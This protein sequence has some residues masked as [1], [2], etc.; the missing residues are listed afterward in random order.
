MTRLPVQG[1]IAAAALAAA[2]FSGFLYRNR[3]EASFADLWLYAALYVGVVLVV[4]AAISF[5]FGR[6]LGSRWSFLLGWC[7]FA[8]FWYRD[9]K[10]FADGSSLMQVLPAQGPVAWAV[11]T[12]TILVLVGILSRRPWFPS[13]AMWFAV[14]IALVPLGQYA[15]F[16]VS[17]GESSA[18]SAS[19]GLAVELGHRP[20][21]YFLLLDGYGRQDVLDELY[22]IDIGPFVDE[23]RREGFVVADRALSA[24]PMTWLSVSAILDQKYQALPGKRGRPGVMARHL[25]LIA[26]ESR[27]H[28]ILKANGYQFVTAATHYGTFCRPSSISEIEECV[29]ERPEIDRA[30]LDSHIR[31]Q[32]AFM[33]PLVGLSNSGSP[34]AWVSAFWDGPELLEDEAAV[35]GKAFLTPDVLDAVE[36]IRTRG[37][38]S[39]LFVFAH[40]MYSHPP[41]TLGPD[42]T[43]LNE[44]VPDLSDGWGDAVAYRNGIECATSQVLELIDNVDP[45]AVIVVQSDHGPT[46]GQIDSLD[47]AINDIGTPETPMENLWARASVLSAVRLPDS[48]RS[49]VSGTYAGVSTF[50]VILDCLSGTPQKPQ[51]EISYWTW[52]NSRSVIEITGDLRTFEA[53]RG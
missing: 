25:A 12:S 37:D 13:A 35:G 45:S 43:F 33:T 16:S 8:L 20:D 23:L 31:Y 6:R 26:G 52:H 24:H 36:T 47:R 4:V 44:G 22:D 10:S 29:N 50:K 53:A 5:V 32:L 41:F 40:M 38:T 34:F 11:A 48:C 18:I 7:A 51:P 46:L 30:I 15:W 27:T 39:P 1:I 2:P 14:T 17:S 3:E 19:A 9:V 28:Q 21:I 49:F 42:C